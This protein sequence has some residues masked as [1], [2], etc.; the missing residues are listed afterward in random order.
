METTLGDCGKYGVMTA[1]GAKEGNR[2]RNTS[3]EGIGVILYESEE[4]GVRHGLYSL[5]YA[6]TNGIARLDS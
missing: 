3:L 6:L 2:S 5:S 4:V 1:A